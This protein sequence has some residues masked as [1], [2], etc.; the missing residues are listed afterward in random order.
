MF[1]EN[2][3]IIKN[4]FGEFKGSGMYMILFFIS[5]IY[6]LIKEDNKKVKAFL[7]YFSIIILLITL[8]QF[9]IS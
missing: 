5:I 2:I 3:E 7:V 9:L 8:N 1:E 4:T 6:I